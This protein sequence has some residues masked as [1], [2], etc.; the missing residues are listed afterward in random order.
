V[1]PGD[2]RFVGSWVLL[3]ELYIAQQRR[4]GITTFYEIVAEDAIFRKTPVQRLLDGIYFVD[5]FANERTFTESILVN[6]GHGASVGIDARFAAP[7]PRIA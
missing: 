4:T 3:I 7:E 1:P 6:V 2:V 5:S